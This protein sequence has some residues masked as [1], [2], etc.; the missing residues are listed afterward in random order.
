MLT[1]TGVQGALFR[2]L[3][4]A[5]ILAIM[6]SL[7]VALTVTP[8]LTL[9]LLGRPRSTGRTSRRYWRGSSARYAR[10]LERLADR[11]GVG[12]GRGG[13][14]LPRGRRR[15]CR[16]SARRFCPSSARGTTGPHVGRAGDVAR[17]VVRLGARVTEALRRDPR[18]RTVAQRIGRAEL[19]EDTWGTHYTEFEVDL[20]P[21]TGEAA[22]TVQD[23]LRRILAGFPGVN[24][25]IRGFLAERIEETLTGST[26]EV[27]V[28]VYGDDLDSLD[29][30]ARRV[31]ET[32]AASPAR[33]TCSTIPRPWPRRSPS[34][35][36]P[37]DLPRY[38]LR[39]DEV[40]AAV[41]TATRGTRIAQ[42]FE[43]NRS[44]RRRGDVV[45]ERRARPEDLR[46]PAGHL[47][48]RPARSSSARWPTSP[49][50]PAGS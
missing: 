49:A 40:L 23:D 11:P 37:S 5:Y 50:R 4:L 30:A 45:P 1:L 34:G 7:V 35:C 46:A 10:V 29:V 18:V 31:A 26:A 3:G 41:E 44:H 6:A 25:A 9:L 39:P 24:F 38:G 13:A 48:R 32:L 47:G 36:G 17:R 14:R 19:S 21:L 28:R 42:M 20:V 33:R 15:P 12:G 27:V 43:G 2:P 16:S 8:A 22:E